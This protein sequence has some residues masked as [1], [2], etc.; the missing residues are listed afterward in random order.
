MSWTTPRT[1][2]TGE[3]VTAPNL[4]T[5]VRDNLLAE[6]SSLAA[7]AGDFFYAS[8]ANLPAKLAA[9]TNGHV[10]QVTNGLP[11]W[12][13]G[14]GSLIRKASDQAYVNVEENDADFAFA[15]EANSAYWVEAGLFND[16]ATD[17]L[18][19]YWTLPS[20]ASGIHGLEDISL[21]GV[22]SSLVG[23]SAVIGTQIGTSATASGDLI[24][25]YALIVIGATAGTA[26]LILDSASA[27]GGTLKANSWMR[28]LRAGAT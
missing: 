28:Y 23:V 9:G 2:V 7:A 27:G 21:S 12:A 6:P 14:S 24:R 25:Y 8:A 18:Q 15:V 11:A 4:N 3:I 16:P 1:W 10:L 13:P 20:G 22:G 5:H 26:Q 19:L 17:N